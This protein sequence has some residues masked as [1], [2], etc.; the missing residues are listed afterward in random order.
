MLDDIRLW[1]E[2]Y[3][4]GKPAIVLNIPGLPPSVNHYLV[5]TRYSTYKTPAAESFQAAARL[6]LME[7]YPAWKPTDLTV[8][9]LFNFQIGPNTKFDVDNRFKVIIDSF[10]GL[11]WKDDH[12]VYS[13][14]G[15]KSVIHPARGQKV[16]DIKRTYMRV[17]LGGSVAAM[18]TPAKTGQISTKRQRSMTK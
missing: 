5:H 17:F 6:A 3:W 11:I 1:L 10:N 13:V 4:E 2:E 14:F 16:G 15:T 8:G 9:V 18:E 12:Q 7:T